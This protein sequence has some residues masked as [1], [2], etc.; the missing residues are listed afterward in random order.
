M[1]QFITFLIITSL[2]TSLD[3]KPDLSFSTHPYGTHQ[4]FLYTI[5]KNTTGPII[6]FGCG[7][8]STGLLHD[9]CKETGRTLITLEDDLE[10]LNIFRK[11]YLGDGYYE[12]NS[13][14]H[15][16]FFV[17][18]KKNIHDPSPEHWLRFFETFE[19]LTT[20]KFDVCFVDQSPWLAR[21]ETVKLMKD[22]ALYVIVHD[23]DYF[24]KTGIFGKTIRPIDL[25]RSIPGEFDFSDMFQYF[26]TYFPPLPWPGETGPPTL[27]GSNFTEELL[28]IN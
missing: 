18:G 17:P 19:Y 2:A 10:W 22:R 11:K 28:K 1:K 25:G 24:P 8:G 5:A 3:A 26:K 12:D 4:P 20:L 16:M 7:N 21:Y 13:G 14:W 6:E 27:I 23:C 15:K 9:L